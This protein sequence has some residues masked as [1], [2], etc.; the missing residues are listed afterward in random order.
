MSERLP[1]LPPGDM[2]PARR[3]FAAT[4]TT[5]RRASS[6]ATFRLARPDGTLIGPPAIW[7]QQPAL[8]MALQHLGGE[9]RYGLGLSDRAAEAVVLVI[10]ERE[11]SPFELFAHVQA[12]A[13]AGWSDDDIAVIRAGGEP[14]G[15]SDDELAALRIGTRLHE[16]ALDAAEFADAVERL[17]GGAL[18]R[19]RLFELTTLVGYYRMLAL[20]LAVFGVEPP[21]TTSY[22]NPTV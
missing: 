5:G 21:L 14:A 15:A 16:R 11:R 1:E 12:A 17:G 9:V 2:T 18:G 7:V 10:A 8:G 19:E 4:F 13:R 22:D 20:Q 6:D 3:E